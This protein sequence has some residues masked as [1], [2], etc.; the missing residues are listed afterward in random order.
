MGVKADMTRQQQD[1]HSDRPVLLLVDDD[2]MIVDSLSFVLKESFSVIS[3]ESRSQARARLQEPGNRPE[4]ALVDL[5][6]PPAPHS[7]DEGFALV[8]EL[9]AINPAMKILV[10]SGQDD[11]RNIQHALTL[12]A[13][14]FIPKPTDVVL[15]KARLDHQIMI[16]EAERQALPVQ[17]YECG[18]I[19]EHTVMDTLRSQIRQL[20]SMPFPVLIEGESGTGKELVAQCLHEQSARH[21]A[22]CLT[23]N[24]AAIAHDL[25]ESQLFGHVK[26]AFTGAA[27]ARAGFFEEAG[28]GTLILDEIGEFPLE[29]Q[30]KLLRALENG[31]YYRIGDTRPRKSEARI[32]A[33]TNR[34]LREEVHKGNFR[35]DLYHRLSVL[36]I[37]VPPLRERGDE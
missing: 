4:L 16:L 27:N 31:E 15:L 6:L 29:L 34:N 7:P 26:G 36:P 21:A 28:N 2:P 23:V 8:Q 9:L 1:V 22:P 19:G 20:A 35:E 17:E 5:G 14:D 25:L 12:G 3:V 11:K 32:I 37:H 13:V 30:P 33:A 18:I 24:C 10:L